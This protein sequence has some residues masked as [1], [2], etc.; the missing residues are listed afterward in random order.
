M[1]K[2]QLDPH[3]SDLL[4]RARQNYSQRML[5]LYLRNSKSVRV[6]QSTISRWLRKNGV[7]NMSPIPPDAEF[8]LYQSMAKLC[9]QER[10]YRRTLSRW[11]GYIVHMRGRGASLP[12]IQQYLLNRGV[13][14]STKSIYRELNMGAE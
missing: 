9:L 2:S 6:N 5:Q 8:L 14:T 7:I 3:R 10:L 11:T 13:A 1:S 4:S 12:E